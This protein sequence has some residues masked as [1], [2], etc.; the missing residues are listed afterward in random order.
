[1]SVTKLADSDMNVFL[2][3]YFSIQISTALIPFLRYLPISST[4]S[5]EPSFL[6]S[7]PVSPT[8]S[9]SL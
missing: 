9:L 6:K 2:K 7:S 1:M 5:L 4:L 8:D 3:E